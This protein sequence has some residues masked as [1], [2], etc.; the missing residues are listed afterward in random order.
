MLVI[1]KSFVLAQIRKQIWKA[2]VFIRISYGICLDPS[3]LFYERRALKRADAS[4]VTHIVS[5]KLQ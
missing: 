3:P 4:K 2:Q 5:L 1:S